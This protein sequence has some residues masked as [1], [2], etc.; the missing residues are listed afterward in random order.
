MDAVSDLLDPKTDAELQDRFV[1]IDEEV[2]KLYDEIAQFYMVGPDR[3]VM[4]RK[5]D[6]RAALDAE[7]YALALRLAERVDRPLEEIHTCFFKISLA[8]HDEL[9][10]LI[11]KVKARMFFDMPGSSIMFGRIDD[12]QQ[13][14]LPMNGVPKDW[15]NYRAA[16]R[17]YDETTTMLTF[18]YKYSDRRCEVR[19]CVDIMGRLMAADPRFLEQDPRYVLPKAETTE[20]ANGES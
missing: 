3:S 8:L 20:L 5:Q 15:T 12:I 2:R 14:L 10:S 16:D 17:I 13:H 7:Q 1:A 9:L 18:C 6:K 19:K 11:S 4:K